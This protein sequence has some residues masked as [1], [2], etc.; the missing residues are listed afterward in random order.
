MPELDSFPDTQAAA[1]AGV[2][3]FNH[4][5]GQFVGS[6]TSSATALRSV[7]SFTWP[8]SSPPATTLSSNRSTSTGP[9]E[10]NK[11]P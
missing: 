10:H 9:F 11:M 1:L 8:R 4:V 2:A 5:S 7:R 6:A 3:P